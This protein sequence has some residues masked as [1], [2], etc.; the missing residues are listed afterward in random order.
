[1]RAYKHDSVTWGGNFDLVYSIFT[2][3]LTDGYLRYYQL[4]KLCCK[5]ESMSVKENIEVLHETVIYSVFSIIYSPDDLPFHTIQGWGIHFLPWM[6]G[7]KCLNGFCIMTGW[8]EIN[9]PMRCQVLYLSR[10]IDH[11]QNYR[12]IGISRK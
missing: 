12:G 2:N 10:I 5:D 3:G 9:F 11:T 4:I 7:F 8:I 1:M 6:G